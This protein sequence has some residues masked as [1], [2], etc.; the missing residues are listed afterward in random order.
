MLIKLFQSRL[1]NK[2]TI[3]APETDVISDVNPTNPIYFKEK[4][5]NLIPDYHIHPDVDQ[6]AP[7]ES[8][9]V[10]SNLCTRNRWYTRC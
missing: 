7:I 10:N 8:N 4:V 3:Y 2:I 5:A 9:E 1:M 6:T